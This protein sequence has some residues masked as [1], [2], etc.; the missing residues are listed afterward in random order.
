[1][2]SSN[3]LETGEFIHIVVTAAS[4]YLQVYLNGDLDVVTRALAGAHA[5]AY[6]HRSVHEFGRIVTSTAKCFNG[7]IAYARFWHGVA[8]SASQVAGLYALRIDPTPAPTGEPTGAP[9]MEPT[10]EP[11]PVPTGLPVSCTAWNSTASGTTDGVYS[12]NPSGSSV[13]ATYEV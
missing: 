7:T 5:P 13:T 1:M 2:S 12:I 3:S 4:D 6:L 11:T 9:T 8:L 10:G